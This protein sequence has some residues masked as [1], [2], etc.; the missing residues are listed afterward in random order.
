MD[1][2]NLDLL[3]V[4]I[5]VAATAALGFT[6]YFSDRQS[7]TNRV[8]FFFSIVTAFWGI[9]NYASY[10]FSDPVLT[11]WL[12][13]G[14][15]F[16]AVLQAFCIYEFFAVFP[17]KTRRYPWQHTYLLVPL[18]AAT[19][20]VTLTPFAFSGILGD[21]S[22]GQ[23]AI[24][25]KGPGL[26]LFAV[27]AVGLVV[28]ALWLLIRTMRKSEG[29]IHEAITVILLGT[30]ITFALIIFFNLILATAFVNP[31][32]IPFGALF[33]FPFILAASYAILRE[34]LFNVKVATT[35]VLVF[36]L[37]VV[38]FVDIIFSD[39]LPQVLLRVGVFVL[40]LV[41]GIN[42]IRGVLR[43][44]QQREHIELLAKQLGETNARQE[45]LIHF[46]SHEVKGFL[47]RYM[48]AFAGLTE[49]DFG[50]LPPPALAIA[51]QLLPQTREDVRMVTDIL[52]ASNLKKGTISFKKEP[53]DLKALV[54]KRFAALK[55]AAEEKDLAMTLSIDGAAAPYAV[56]GDEAQF[57]DHV[58]QNLI[59]NSINYTPTGKVEV[60]L[61]KEDGRIV[62]AVKDT[63]VGI[64]EEDKQRLFTEGGHGKESIKV[65]AHSTGYGLYIAKEVVE[66]HGGTIRAESEGAGKGSRFVVELPAKA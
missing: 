14:V 31:R 52:Q 20:I 11:I 1:L 19:A 58:L 6:V 22:A 50:A 66:A 51:Q 44:V 18:V 34:H 26:I 41:F 37:A 5:V 53:F 30:A 56:T 57:G 45:G 29:E 35:A 64:T 12:L 2:V 28:R 39:T 43:E 17:G 62:F 3:T 25:E 24:V 21:V 46:I 48:S 8:F 38:S 65:N 36:V 10:Q 27:V 15:L 60:S 9:V 32:Y 49:G 23:V 55:P 16:F 54:E 13:R 59:Q 47:A 40:I 63:G 4:G 7:A 42:L 61:G 33:M